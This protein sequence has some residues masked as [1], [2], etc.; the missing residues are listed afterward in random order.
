MWGS[1]LIQHNLPKRESKK[2]FTCNNS[3]KICVICTWIWVIYTSPNL[4]WRLSTC[5]YAPIRNM[6]LARRWILDGFIFGN[7]N[8][9]LSFLSNQSWPVEKRRVKMT[10]LIDPISTKFKEMMR[11]VWKGSKLSLGFTNCVHLLCLLWNVYKPSQPHCK[12]L[13]KITQSQIEMD[14][15]SL[16]VVF[17]M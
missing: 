7:S 14:F 13:G 6:Q 16:Q 1:N 2:T 4:W 9:I 10:S 15:N 5:M 11:R 3:D 12:A 17:F 8:L